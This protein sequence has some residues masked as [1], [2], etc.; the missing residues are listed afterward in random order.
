MPE[1]YNFL[2]GGRVAMT[3][4]HAAGA[5]PNNTINQAGH[6]IAA[7]LGLSRYY[8]EQRDSFSLGRAEYKPFNHVFQVVITPTDPCGGTIDEDYIHAGSDPAAFVVVDTAEER[9]ELQA[10]IGKMVVDFL[11]AEGKVEGVEKDED[12]AG[13]LDDFLAHWGASRD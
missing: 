3:L 13:A 8:F 10:K 11:M 5:D 6:A 2:R 1:Y 9:S 7:T 4:Q 12:V